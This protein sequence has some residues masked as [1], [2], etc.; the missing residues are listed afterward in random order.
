MLLELENVSRSY[1]GRNGSRVDAVQNVDLAMEPGEFVAV[2]GPSGS[3]KSTLLLIAGG[4]L[5]PDTGTVHVLGKQPYAMNADERS[6]F[7]S[8]TLGFVFQQF[9]L[10]PYLSVLENVLAPSLGAAIRGAN[11]RAEQLVARFGLDNRIGH[12][13]GEMSTGERQRTAMARALMNH[14]KLLLADEPTGNL[15]Q[16]NQDLL[17]DCLREEA[18]CGTAVLLVTHD[19]QAAGRADRT[20]GLHDGQ[21][22]QK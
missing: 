8:V 4:L 7:R 6:R 18:S 9:H 10:V 14:P 20:I 15:D 17:L 21:L 5:A 11:S 12:L 2:G 22:H 13:P 16:E 1:R 19:Q 3:G